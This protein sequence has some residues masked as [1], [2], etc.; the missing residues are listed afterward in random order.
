MGCQVP[1]LRRWKKESST[2]YTNWRNRAPR[3]ATHRA[4]GDSLEN[5]PAAGY[6]AASAMPPP[7][8]GCWRGLSTA[9]AGDMRTTW[10]FS[11]AGQILF[12]PGAVEQLRSIVARLRLSRVLIVTDAVLVEAGI[13]NEV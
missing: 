5:G 7:L 1:G 10:T 3:S 2:P 8:A 4:T 12:G 6:N 11:S 9:Q 13:V